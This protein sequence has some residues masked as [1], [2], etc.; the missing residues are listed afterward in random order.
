MKR[1]LSAMVLLAV[2]T[3]LLALPASGQETT[4]EIPPAQ[5]EAWQT[6]VAADLTAMTATA[7][8]ADETPAPNVIIVTPPAPAA[9]GSSIADTLEQFLP[10]L[11]VVALLAIGFY[12]GKSNPKGAVVYYQ[13]ALQRADQ[14]PMT[15]DDLIVRG[16]LYLQGYSFVKHEDGT[17]T[18]TPPTPTQRE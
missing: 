6:Q 17:Y 9:T 13:D 8:A 1:L 15:F 3:L 4:P 16:Q 14:T 2:M 5:L 18:V 11:I 10:T 12:I 7:V